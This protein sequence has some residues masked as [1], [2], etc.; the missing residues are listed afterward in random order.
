MSAPGRHGALRLALFYRLAFPDI[1][2]ILL[3]SF[4]EELVVGGIVYLCI[5]V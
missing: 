4:M 2:R 3:S 1:Y 5:C